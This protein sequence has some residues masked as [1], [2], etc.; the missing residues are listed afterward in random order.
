MY[1]AMAFATRLLL[2]I[3]ATMMN[4]QNLLHC[5]RERLND[6]KE[7]WVCPIQQSIC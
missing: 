7:Y 3:N 4:Q 1:E 2:A 6:I 5:I